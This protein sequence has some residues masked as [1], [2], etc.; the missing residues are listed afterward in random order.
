[1]GAT[2]D[3]AWRR[4]AAARTRRTSPVTPL[5]RCGQLERL[6]GAGPAAGAVVVTAPV[7]RPLD[8]PVPVCGGARRDAG[9]TVDLHGPG[10]GHEEAH[11]LARIENEPVL[12]PAAAPAADGEVTGAVVAEIGDG[13]R[14]RA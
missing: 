4:F 13:D 2:E 12:L 9:G 6:P 11:V 1:M 3:A 10:R 8:V 7:P 5:G 14:S